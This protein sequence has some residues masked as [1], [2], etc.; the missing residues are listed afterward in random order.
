MGRGDLGMGIL[1]NFPVLYHLFGVRG[2]GMCI[3]CNFIIFVIGEEDLLN[4]TVWRQY[5]G[6]FIILDGQRGNVLLFRGM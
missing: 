5:V 3:Y 1:V 2:T 6:V 4:G